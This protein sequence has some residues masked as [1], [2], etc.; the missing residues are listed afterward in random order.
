MKWMSRAMCALAALEQA[1]RLCLAIHMHTPIAM[2]P[3]QNVLN[4]Q[5]LQA[6]THA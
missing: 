1:A 2:R 4:L 6:L 3:E 5:L